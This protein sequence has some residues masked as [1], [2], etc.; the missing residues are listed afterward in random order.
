MS[1]ENDAN[2]R[3]WVM[4]DHAETLDL[5]DG[6]YVTLRG[7]SRGCVFL[8]ATEWKIDLSGNAGCLDSMAMPMCPVEE[9]RKAAIA[10]AARGLRGALDAALRAA[11]A[12]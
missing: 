2:P 6:Y 4:T 11:E 7:S 3:H 1:T 12:S 5:G 8:A 9:A 10:W